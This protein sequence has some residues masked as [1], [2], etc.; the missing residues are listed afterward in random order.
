MPAAFNHPAGSKQSRGKCPD[1]DEIP[2]GY[3]LTVVTNDT[4][5]EGDDLTAAAAA[6]AAASA[7]RN[8]IALKGSSLAILLEMARTC[9]LYVITQV[10]SDEVENKVVDALEQAG[11]FDAGLSPHK[12]LFCETELGRAAMVRQIEPMLHVESSAVVLESL[13]PF[14]PNLVVVK[15]PYNVSSLSSAPAGRGGGGGGNVAIVDDLSQY[16]M[17]ASSPT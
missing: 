13:K 16:F 6:A 3:Q 7:E 14:I 10:T 15:T 2:V 8:S 4:I 1:H 17:Q 5:F 9:D 11:V 12:V